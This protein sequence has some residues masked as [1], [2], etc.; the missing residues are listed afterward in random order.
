M[1]HEPLDAV[2]AQR[3]LITKAAIAGSMLT[4]PPLVRFPEVEDAGWGAIH[5][6]LTG[7][8]DAETAV[9]RMQAA[10]EEVLA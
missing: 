3:L 5:D 7:E 2:D 1:E 8:I 10:A 4:Y 6:A 9:A